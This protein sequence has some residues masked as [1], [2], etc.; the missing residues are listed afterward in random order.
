MQ[1]PTHRQRPGFWGHPHVH[2]QRPLD[3][4]TSMTGY[5]HSYLSLSTVDL[6]STKNPETFPKIDVAQPALHAEPCIQLLF[7]RK[8]WSA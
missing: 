8:L 5:I 4:Y 3:V 6:F 2:Q 7:L 1:F